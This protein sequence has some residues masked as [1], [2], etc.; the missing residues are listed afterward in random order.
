[1]T[2][3][4]SPGNHRVV[5]AHLDHL[6]RT[7]ALPRTIEYRRGLLR[8]L[9]RTLPVDLLDA[10]RDHLDDWQSGLQ[11]SPVTLS[12]Y[13]AGISCFY[14]WAVELGWLEVDP[15]ARLP[16]TRV[17]R[18]RPRPV[19]EAD[20]RLAIQCAP[21]PIRTW[22]ILAAF[23]GLR[24]VEVAGMRREDVVEH[25]GRLFLDGVGKGHK[26]FRLPVPDDVAAVLRP[27]LV[28]PPGPL[29]WTAY[30]RLP[31]RPRDVSRQ[32]GTFFRRLGMPYGIHQM[33]HSF[34]SRLY[35]QTRDLLLVQSAM[36]H[37]SPTTTRGYV[38]TVEGHTVAAMD[39]LATRS[40]AFL[41]NAGDDEEVA[42]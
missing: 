2:D 41:A 10:T 16:R 38:E 1:M 21:E 25:G 13:T 39:R 29:W 15:S 36:R 17:P 27:H 31:S 19:P 3:E 18:R 20:L 22:L 11:V 32:T 35:A 12:S 23:M 30:G 8:R 5:R 34:G 6:R 40:L 28:G 37:E 4:L 26:P 33:R 7:G 42:G 9:A 14:R 24:A